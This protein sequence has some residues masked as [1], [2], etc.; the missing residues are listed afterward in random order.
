MCY[1]QWCWLVTDFMTILWF[2]G[3]TIAAQKDCGLA[4]QVAE[5]LCGKTEFLTVQTLRRLHRS[6]SDDHVCASPLHACQGLKHD[7][8]PVQ[9]TQPGGRV[10]H[11]ILTAHVVNGHGHLELFLGAINNVE[12]EECR[13]YHHNIRPLFDIERNFPHSSSEL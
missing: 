5:Q 12:I 6:I 13:F 9:T 2:Q 4:L 7:A 10:D 11:G 1:R 8:I 3:W